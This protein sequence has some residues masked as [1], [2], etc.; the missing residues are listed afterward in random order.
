MNRPLAILLTLL[1]VVSAVWWASPYQLGVVVGESMSPT[2]H[3][4][5]L[6][7]IDRNAFRNRPP[8]RGE[9]VAFRHG[10]ALYVKRVHAVERETFVMLADGEL[11]NR[12]MVMPVSGRYEAKLR[13]AVAHRPNGLS[14][15]PIHVP[16]GSFYAIGDNL[17]R[18][19]DSRELGPIE[20]GALLGSVRTIS[21]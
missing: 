14:F 20:Y 8:A 3:S 16:V 9:I 7:V 4:G 19:F 18:S 15:V 5:Q 12:E 1:G 21:G 17:G 6:I 13:L 2:L 11:G 10:R